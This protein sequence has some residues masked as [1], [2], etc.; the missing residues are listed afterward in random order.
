MAGR[1]PHQTGR[2]EGMESGFG[3]YNERNCQETDQIRG[4]KQ[5][6]VGCE[7]AES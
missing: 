5:I 2:E 1:F 4:K 6:A 7:G 3:K